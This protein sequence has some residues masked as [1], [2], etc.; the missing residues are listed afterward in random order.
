MKNLFAH[1]RREPVSSP[2]NENSCRLESVVAAISRSQAMIEFDINGFVVSVNDNFLGAVGYARQDV[3]GQH[4]RMFMP[5]QERQSEDYRRF[6]ERLG[7]GEFL[8]GEYKRIGNG[9]R[10]VWIQATYNPL[11][12]RNGKPC[13]VIK[14]ATDITS[15]K[16]RSLDLAG[17][18][19]AIGRSQAEIQFT[20][21]GIILSANENFR[22]AL[23]YS[24]SEIIGKHHRMFCDPAYT[25]SPEYEQFW[26]SL[27]TGKYSSHEFKRLHRDGH[28]VWIQASYNP[29]LDADGKPW[30]VVKFATD[31]TEQ[32]M[33]REVASRLSLVADNTDNSVIITNAKREIEYVNDGF[34][35]MTGY[36]AE[37]V[38]GRRPGEILQ[39]KLSDAK[40]ISR[41][42][43]K[44]NRGQPFYE[45]ILN[46]NKQREP[47]WISLAINPVRDDSGQI[48]RFISVQA[49]ITET[50]QKAL[51]YT[52]K[53]NA[54]NESNVM[55]EW[56]AD[57]IIESANQLLSSR[58]AVT[59]GSEVSLVRLLTSAEIQRLAAG[60]RLRRELDWPSASGSKIF[61]DAV[62]AGLVD[63]N[64]QVTRILMCAVDISDRRRAVEETTRAVKDVLQ[65]GEKIA[66]IVSTIDTI[67]FQINLL[68]LNAAIEAARAGD[69]GKGFEVVAAEVTLLA[70][71]SAE[72]ATGIGA[73]V[74]ENRNRMATMA[75]SL[76]ALESGRNSAHTAKMPQGHFV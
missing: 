30:K 22:A 29:I 6:W 36:K 44:L 62:F 7:S 14:F 69:A 28:D 75:A 39:G 21:D 3:I 34:E 23:G 19:A 13:G 15:E 32:V 68:A 4:H 35:R 65:S 55:A 54:I 63:L 1:W 56:S 76:T 70:N 57:G 72:A 2:D 64:G 9:G 16:L 8:A 33:R 73:L 20:L 41:I 59:S 60:E 66:E 40:V 25:S 17:Q 46:Y 5:E 38:M 49:N 10:V 48:E 74:G 37:E 52:T 18:I 45:E 43:D 50:K 31:I 71:R 47:Y 58:Q 53:L 61:L 67:S 12:D 51:E 42:R 11:I 24:E 27:R 26:Q